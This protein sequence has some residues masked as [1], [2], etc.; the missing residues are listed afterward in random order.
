MAFMHGRL[1]F[2]WTGCSSYL[3]GD[4]KAVLVPVRVFSLKSFTAGALAATFRILSRKK[5]MT[6][7]I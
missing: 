4:E 3:L 7:D 1:Q 6:G 5:N 2:N